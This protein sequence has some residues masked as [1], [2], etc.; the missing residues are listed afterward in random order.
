MAHMNNLIVQIGLRVGDDRGASVMEYSLLLALI[1]IVCLLAVL[2]F[3]ESVSTT[4]S[5]SGRSIASP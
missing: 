4:V 2:M 1:A 5:E 3:G